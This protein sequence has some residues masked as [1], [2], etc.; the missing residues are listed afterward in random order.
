MEMNDEAKTKAPAL[1]TGEPAK[2]V[3]MVIVEQPGGVNHIYANAITL[4][5]TGYDMMI[6]FAK[7]FRVP[8]LP[9]TEPVNRVE[10]RAAV[11]LSWSEAKFLRNS[12]S[13]AIEKFEKLN[14]EIDATPALPPSL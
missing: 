9:D 6:W 2:P 8:D 4:G 7:I 11:S 1:S 10:Q 14:G 12:L 5:V 13:D 3:K